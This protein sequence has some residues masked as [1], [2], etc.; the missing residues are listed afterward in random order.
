MSVSES[1]TD[2]ES[3]TEEIKYN[4]AIFFDNEQRHIID[5][6]N[7]CNENM[8]VVK[9]TSSDFNDYGMLPFIDI[10][11]VRR[12]DEHL[13]N[14]Q[15]MTKTYLEGIKPYIDQLKTVENLKNNLSTNAFNTLDTLLS[16]LPDNKDDYDNISGMEYEHFKILYD[17]IKENIH[18]NNLV[19]LFDFD[20]TITKVEGIIDFNSINE[21]NEYIKQYEADLPINKTIDNTITAESF[22]EYLC[23]GYIRL[24][25]LKLIMNF[26]FE[27]NIDIY[28]LTNNPLCIGNKLFQELLSVLTTNYKKICSYN[29]MKNK[30]VALHK[31]DELL[32]SKIC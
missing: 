7:G 17:W 8:K 1:K 2:I 26:L 12:L 29:T 20:R 6:Q 24:N 13:T 11:S 10:D 5:V 21:M 14:I 30:F 23:G 32:F 9:I 4:K 16:I 28:I 18:I 27:N 25:N 22:M 31:H 19:A 15:K 3:K